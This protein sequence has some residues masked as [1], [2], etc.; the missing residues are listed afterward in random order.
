MGLVSTH[1]RSPISLN[2]SQHLIVTLPRAEQEVPLKWLFQQD[3]IS[4]ALKY[5][6][7]SATMQERWLKKRQKAAESNMVHLAVNEGLLSQ[8]GIKDMLARGGRTVGH[9]N[10]SQRANSC[11]QAMLDQSGRP[12]KWIPET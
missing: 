3:D 10:H 9:F 2:P 5:A 7:Q 8:R 1:H 11:L 12:I 6:T 4:T